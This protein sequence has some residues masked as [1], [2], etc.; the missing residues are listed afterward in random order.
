MSY[1]NFKYSTTC[2][3][4]ANEWFHGI[5]DWLKGVAPK[6]HQVGCFQDLSLHREVLESFL[7]IPLQGNA[8]A[9]R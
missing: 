7:E 6:K 1:E 9:F 3:T 2:G 5:L 8:V 4:L